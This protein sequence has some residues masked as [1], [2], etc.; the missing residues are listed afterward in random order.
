M[1]TPRQL[2]RRFDDYVVEFALE[3]LQAGERVAL[4]TLVKIEGSSPRPLGAQMAVAESGVW[5]GYLSGGCIERAVVAEAVAAIAAGANRQVRYGRGSKYIDIQLP[6]GSAIELYFDVLIDQRALASIVDDINSRK[7]A[8]MTIRS[9]DTFLR[10]Y[11]PRRR[12]IVA[13]V[14]PSAVR[15]ALLGAQADFDTLLYSPDD[16]TREAPELAGIRTFPIDNAKQIRLPADERTAIVCMFH[17]HD[18]EQEIIPAALQTN[19]FYIGA[20]GSRKTH[21]SRIL[22]LVELGIEPRQIARIHGPAGL[23][24]SAKSAH[25]I[26]ISILSEIIRADLSVSTTTLTASSDEG[27]FA[28]DMANA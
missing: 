7:V 13:G 16:S 14:G 17:D 26:A 22:Q 8:L 20:M 19:A 10:R 27:S 6:C 9:S 3:R 28:H 18:R 15:L 2:W 1:N 23:F 11:E 21:Q 24:S 5:T 12:L 25:D 4:V